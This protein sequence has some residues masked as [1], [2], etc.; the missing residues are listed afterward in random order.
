MCEHGEVQRDNSLNY[1][2]H[3]C[4]EFSSTTP[5]PPITTELLFTPCMQ[6]L[7]GEV[8]SILDFYSCPGMR[9]KTHSQT[10]F[11]IFYFI[12]FSKFSVIYSLVWIKKLKTQPKVFFL[13]SLELRFFNDTRMLSESLCW[14]SACEDRGFAK[15]R[16]CCTA[17]LWAIN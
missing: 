16:H 3:I 1:L 14:Q 8:E 7:L 10:F 17:V 9:N 13:S 12:L 6:D 2:R 15:C 5:H 4:G 11:G